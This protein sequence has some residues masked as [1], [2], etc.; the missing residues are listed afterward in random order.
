MATASLQLPRVASSSSWA[1]AETAHWVSLQAALPGES[2]RGEVEETLSL[3]WWAGQRSA[4]L[5]EALARGLGLAP[6]SLRLWTP[7]LQTG[8]LL[9]A[10]QR[11]GQPQK[12]S[13]PEC[14]PLRLFLPPVQHSD[15]EV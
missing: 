14:S 4:G 2:L 9:T 11:A 8:S 5:V 10:V 1:L 6:W 12:R 3:G 13:S 7:P 15:G